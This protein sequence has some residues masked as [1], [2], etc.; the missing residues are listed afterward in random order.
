MNN[1]HTPILTCVG[2]CFGMLLVRGV[3]G[4]EH[5]FTPPPDEKL[6]STGESGSGN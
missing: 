6:G 5:K 2:Q 3:S 1:A 4:S